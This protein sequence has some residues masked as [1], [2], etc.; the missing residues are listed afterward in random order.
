MATLKR[1]K[2][3]PASRPKN[4][5]FRKRKTDRGFTLLELIVVILILVTMLTLAIPSIDSMYREQALQSKLDAFHQ[6]VQRSRWQAIDQKSS[7]QLVW[8]EKAI[9]IR[10]ELVPESSSKA[11]S[12]NLGPPE[13]PLSKGETYTIRKTY[14]DLEEST[15]QWT[16]WP[17]GNCEA[18][19]VA[20]EGPD[21]T[22]VA[23][24]D[25]LCAEYSLK[26][27]ELK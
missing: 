12:V 18:A 1:M 25:P 23:L 10:A 4:A 21:G 8:G 9:R 27:F 16:F 3:P 14:T 11:V 20:Y 24:Y 2:L 13:I 19:E 5:R 17:S 7:T 26:K 6:L 15:P 22:W